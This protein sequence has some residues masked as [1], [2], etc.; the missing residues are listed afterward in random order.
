MGKAVLHMIGNDQPPAS[1]KPPPRSAVEGI[2]D[3]ALETLASLQT[4]LASLE[5][6]SSG[7]PLPA[8][9][10]LLIAPEDLR[11]RLLALHGH[12][13]AVVDELRRA[14]RDPRDSAAPPG[15]RLVGRLQDL[16]TQFLNVTGIRCE[17]DISADHAHF[18]E[19]ACE[20]IYWTICE[21]LANVRRHAHA[22]AVKLSSGVLEG[23]FVYFRV[24]DNGVGLAARAGQNAP[25]GAG[26]LGLWSVERH[27]NQIDGS[28][29]IE[30]AAGLTVTIVLPREPAATRT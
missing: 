19:R 23:G 16:C 13:Q 21:L 12:V 18:G 20:V 10:W 22:T 30:S 4:E 9:H 24:E 6:R 27:L 14:A 1:A 15:W 25:H 5:R 2:C 17:L 28:L 11:E 29:E 7:E 26:G 3:R 8:G